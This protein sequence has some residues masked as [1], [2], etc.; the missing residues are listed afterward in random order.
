[1]KNQNVLSGGKLAGGI[2][3]TY[4]AMAAQWIPYIKSKNILNK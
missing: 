4:Q 3:L 2:M 1:M